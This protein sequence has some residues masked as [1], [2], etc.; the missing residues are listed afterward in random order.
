MMASEP[1][2]SEQRTLRRVRRRLVPFA[3]ICY[4]VA[5]IDRVNVGFAATE[6]QRDLGL[7]ATAVWHRR[8]T[9]LSRLLPVRDSQQPDPRARRRAAMDRAHHD[10][11]G[12]R[13]D[14]DDVRH[15]RVV[16]HG[17]ARLLLGIAE[18]GFFPG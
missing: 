12:P 7:S 15:R 13:L 9:V 16:V 1:E 10:R 2:P 5:Y 18:A 6:L 8:R 14:G 11:L 3:F 17:L 4:V